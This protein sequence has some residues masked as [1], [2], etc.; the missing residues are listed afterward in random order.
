MQIIIA[1][2]ILKLTS[3]ADQRQ[4]RTA[5]YSGNIG[6]YGR[7]TRSINANRAG[8]FAA[9][10]GRDNLDALT[11]LGSTLSLRSGALTW[12]ISGSTAAPRAPCGG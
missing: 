7:R 2:L 5:N 8:K 4:F 6:R 3:S 11:R 12:L 1:H 10:V 9:G